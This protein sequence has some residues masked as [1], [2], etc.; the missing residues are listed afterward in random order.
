VNAIQKQLSG[1]KNVLQK[2]H[3]TFFD[4]GF[5]EPHAKLDVVTLLNFATH[6]RQNKMNL[7]KHLRKNNSYSQRGVT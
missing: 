7:K 5:T 4:S 3:K 6:H 2:P 1:L